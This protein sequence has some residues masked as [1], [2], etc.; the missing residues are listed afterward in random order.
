M[1]SRRPETIIKKTWDA[2]EALLETSKEAQTLVGRVNERLNMETP[3]YIE[4]E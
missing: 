3:D 1:Q 4:T 2:Y